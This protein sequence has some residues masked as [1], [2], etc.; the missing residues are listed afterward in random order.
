M[1]VDIPPG[2]FVAGCVRSRLWMIQSRPVH[3]VGLDVFDLAVEGFGTEDPEPVRGLIGGVHVLLVL[4][5]RHGE[6]LVI[7]FVGQEQATRVAFL[8]P[9]GRD[10]MLFYLMVSSFEGLGANVELGYPCEHGSTAFC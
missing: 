2:T 8:H 6:H 10:E 5:Q 4:P 3:L 7:F 1:S 9:Q